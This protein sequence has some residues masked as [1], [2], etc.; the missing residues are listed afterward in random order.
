MTERERLEL[1]ERIKR[2]FTNVK[3]Q[4]KY[5]GDLQALRYLVTEKQEITTPKDAQMIKDLILFTHQDHHY[6]LPIKMIALLTHPEQVNETTR[7]GVI[8]TCQG[9]T[10]T[11]FGVSAGRLCDYF[12]QDQ[13]QVV[14]E[15]LE[16][17]HDLVPPHSE[18]DVNSLSD[19]DRERYEWW[20]SKRDQFIQKAL[21]Y[22]RECSE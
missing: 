14:I 16:N 11:I 13:R 4:S 2:A 19:S 5:P 10:D 22:W 17:Y 15:F 1:A 7:R 20:Q 9:D 3:P 18:A 12:T 8:R 21:K 6:H